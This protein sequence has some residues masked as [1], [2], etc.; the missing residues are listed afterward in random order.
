MDDLKTTGR[1]L[2]SHTDVADAVRQGKA[3]T[4]PAVEA[5]RP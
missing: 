5:R 3:D 2:S 4:G 1:P